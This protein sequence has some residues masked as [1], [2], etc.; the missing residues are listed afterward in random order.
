MGNGEVGSEVHGSEVH[1][2]GCARCPR[3]SSAF[4]TGWKAYRVEDR[5]LGEPA[6]LAFYC[7][8][9]ARLEFGERD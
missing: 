2:L 7:P 4:A 5:E 1:V 8:P 3:V 6:R 9:C